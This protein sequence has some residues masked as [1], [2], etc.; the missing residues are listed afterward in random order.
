MKLSAQPINEE[1]KHLIHQQSLRILSEV[2]I[3]YL[4]DKALPLLAAHGVRVDKERNLAYIPAEVVEHALSTA[5]KS[6]TLGARN[7]KYNYP[8]PSSVTRY[9]IDGTAAFTIDF[10]DGQRR[11]GTQQDIFDALRIFQ[12]ADMGIMAWAPVCASDT[13]AE[14]R[15]LHEFF[16]MIK[17]GVLG[18]TGAVGQRFVQ[19]LANHPLVRSSSTNGVRAECW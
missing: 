19:L 15:P 6:F 8:M 4:G 9:A 7:P 17:V 12:E 14:T 5:P 2:G 10:N 16:T 11:Y 13:P 1:E 18:A 3:K